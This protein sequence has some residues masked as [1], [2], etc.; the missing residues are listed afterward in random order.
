MDH[1]IWHEQQ[2]EQTMIKSADIHSTTYLWNEEK[3]S[4]DNMGLLKRTDLKQPFNKCLHVSQKSLLG[5]HMDYNAYTCILEIHTKGTLQVIST[6]LDSWKRRISFDGLVHNIQEHWLSFNRLEK[7]IIN[8][9]D[10]SS[11]FIFIS[12][13]TQH[14]LL[15]FFHR[16]WL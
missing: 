5:E 12:P 4:T 1:S 2:W 15:S 6:H 11:H 13:L 9:Y 7:S 16:L 10:I 8:K 14:T 3:D